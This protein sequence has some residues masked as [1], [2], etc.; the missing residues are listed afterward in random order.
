MKMIHKKTTIVFVFLS[1]FIKQMGYTQK[2]SKKMHKANEAYNEFAFTKASKLYTELA[3]KDDATAIV[4][5]KLADSYYY[6]SNY[7]E[8]LLWYSKAMENGESISPEY[9]FRYAQT[10]KAAQK[11]LEAA[12]VLKNYFKLTEKKDRSDDWLPENFLSKI[13]EQSGRYEIK[14]IKNNSAYSDFGAAFW[15]DDK[16]LYSSAKEV[17]LS[18]KAKHNWDNK[19]F[20]K[21]YEAT[22]TADGELENDKILK[23]K[24]N[25]KYHQ[26]TPVI[27]KDGKTMYFTGTNYSSGELGRS[28]KL[29]ISY[30]KIYKAHYINNEW[31]NIEEL[32]YPV[33]SSG[34]SSGH[35]AL[36]PDDKE[37]YFVSDRNNEIGNSDLYV[38][39]ITEAYQISNEVKSLGD[40]INTLGRETYPFIDESGIL[41]FSSDGHPGLGGLDVF[42][43]VKDEEGVY[44]VM[45]LGDGVNSRYD[46]FGYAINE[47]TK[48]GYFSSNRNGNDD[49]YGF[50]ENKPKKMPFSIKPIISGVLK[51]SI[52]EIPIAQV[53]IEVYDLDNNKVATHYTDNDGN[54]SLRLEPYKSYRLVFKK[55]GLIEATELISSM[56]QLEKKN[57]SPN[58]YN[59]MEVIVANKIVVLSEG[60]DLTQ[61][62]EL[63]PIYFDFEGFIIRESSKKELNK[64]VQLLLARPNISLKVQSHTDSRG[65]KELNMTLS[66]NRASSTVNY[67][68][69]AGIEKERI[70]GEGFGDTEL[71]NKCEK[72]VKCSEGEHQ[73]NRRSEFI[74]IKKQ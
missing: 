28:N 13:A 74:I 41:Y 49:L 65:R 22:I 30:L 8:A 73:L 69:N 67:I 18:L 55:E 32:P 66:K 4:Y 43:A 38:V 62:L 15:G 23:G 6:N 16:I 68:V 12:L 48:K 70:S 47:E 25:S 10:L 57:I 45:N 27:T 34:F 40:E 54:Y 59:E 20:L 42:A 24:V 53:A 39:N 2:Q 26:S 11:Y 29:D 35:P 17:G 60:D 7:S 1:L 51:D 56:K 63:S 64:I 50:K 61:K 19:P 44:H 21:I 58:L 31:E 14:N 9:Y 52:T 3:N 37:L 72:G 5:A 71:I 46:D 33:N 36:S